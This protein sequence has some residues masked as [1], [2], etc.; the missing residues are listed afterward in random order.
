MRGDI[1]VD[2]SPSAKPRRVRL[3]SATIAL[4]LRAALGGAVLGAARQHHVDL[5]VVRQVVQ[6]D[7]DVPAVHLPLIERLRA[8]IEAGRVAEADRVGG[9]EQ[10]ERRMRLDDPALIEQRQPSFEL[11]ARAG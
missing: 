6:R 9:G 2:R 1:T 7:H 10:P 8:V 3:A 5:A 11:R 4:D